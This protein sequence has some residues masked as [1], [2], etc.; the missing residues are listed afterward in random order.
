MIE[1]ES[2]LP[3]EYHNLEALE[4]A[5][6]KELGATGDETGAVLSD[7]YKQL[8]AVRASDSPS[9]DELARIAYQIEQLTNKRNVVYGKYLRELSRWGY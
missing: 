8:R 7:L 2:S 6:R 1:G 4:F 5:L 9:P 3:P